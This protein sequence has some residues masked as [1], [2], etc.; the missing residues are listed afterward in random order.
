MRH[1]IGVRLLLLAVL[2]LSACSERVPQL[3][4]IG[5]D[6][7]VLAFGDSIT[8][9]TGAAEAESY[10]AVLAELIGRNVVRAGVPGE[11]SAQGVQRLPSALEMH[12]PKIVLLCLG[13]ND[14]LRKV[15]DATIRANLRA[16]IQTARGHGAA[17]VLLGVPRPALFGGAARFYAELAKEFGLHYQADVLNDVLKKPGLKSDPIHPNA[18][19][20]RVIA[21]EV[22]ALLKRAGAL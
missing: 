13:G 22:A 5:P 20:Y 3:P 7:V 16:M 14:M 17:V 21:E 6:D 10:P 4:R 18:Q 11:L 1:V 12:R 15:D 8:F 19:G 2:V 9:G